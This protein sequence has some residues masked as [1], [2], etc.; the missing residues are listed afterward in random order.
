MHDSPQ[1]TSAVDAVRCLY[2]A[3]IAEREGHEEAA[4][5]WKEM[6]EDWLKDRKLNKGR[7]EE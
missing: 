2:P 1:A 6:A 7:P 4:R 3:R 5:R